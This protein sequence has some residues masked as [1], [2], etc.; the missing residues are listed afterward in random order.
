MDFASEP[1]GSLKS[2]PIGSIRYGYVLYG[3]SGKVMSS[4]ISFG[5]LASGL[6]TDAIVEAY[7]NVQKARLITP[8]E[9]RIAELTE[10]QSEVDDIKTLMNTVKSYAYDINKVGAFD[11]K[12]ASSSDTSKLSVSGVTTSAQL[13]TYEVL[14]TTLAKA[15]KEY[16][17]GVADT[18]VTQ[19]G[20]GTIQITSDGVTVDVAITSSNNT[21]AGI[22]DAINAAANI[23]VTASIVNDGGASP[24]RLV[25]TSKTL[26]TAAAITQNIASV[27]SLTYDA[28]TST[29]AVNQ[30]SN[31]SISVNGLTITGRSNTFTEAIPGVTFTASATHTDAA[32]PMRITVTNNTSAMKS[33]ISGFINAYNEVVAAMQE[34]FTYDSA[35]QTGGVLFSDETLQSIQGRLNNIIIGV[36][37][38]GTN[39]YQSL[40]DIGITMGTDN[41]LTMDSSKL[42]AALTSKLSDVKILFQGNG[43]SK[44]IA[45]KT[46]DYIYNMTNDGTGTLTR[47]EQIYQD[48]I[49]YLNE[50]L[51]ERNDRIDNYEAELRARFAYME[52]VISSLKAQESTISGMQATIENIYKKG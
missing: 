39:A 18:N 40:S 34:N 30:P 38:F 7:V 31:A 25:L 51:E 24:Y 43:T 47:K 35:T 17:N 23:P 22:R 20:T 19:F 4:S 33:S 3:E 8:L 11:T 5:G 44:A 50:L 37:N 36:Y 1:P 6:D 29:A 2:F 28:A 14:V 16:F 13:G 10:K 52:E 12:T 48:N 32:N 42:D 46:Y 26:G 15:D 49:D 9:N 45:G 27:L 41:L 21:L